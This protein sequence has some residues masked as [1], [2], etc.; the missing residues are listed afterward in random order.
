MKLGFDRFDLE[1]E[2]VNASMII[3][4]LELFREVFDLSDKEDNFILGLIS[5]YDKR[6]ER[7]MSIFEN[8]VKEKQI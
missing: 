8:M 5:I 2:I 4:D 6:H 3:Q 1:T 7:L